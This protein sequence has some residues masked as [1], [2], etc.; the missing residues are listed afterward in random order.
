MATL[1]SGEKR[2]EELVERLNR[3]PD[4]RDKVEELLDI[5]DNKSGDANKADD[6]EDL[7]YEELRDMGQRILQDWAE[8]KHD[9]VVGETEKR[10]ELSRKEKRALLARDVRANRISE[11]VYRQRAKQ[12]RPSCLAAGVTCRGYSRR[13]QRENNLVSKLTMPPFGISSPPLSRILDGLPLQIVDCGSGGD[14]VTRSWNNAR[15]AQR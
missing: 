15:I 7:I 3:P 5:A 13:L 9:R 10:E 14:L 12:V 6:A 1:K 2:T 11:Q 4:F 8:R